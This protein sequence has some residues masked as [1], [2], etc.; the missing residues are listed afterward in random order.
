MRIAAGDEGKTMYV[1]CYGSYEYLVMPFGL[2]NAS[3]TF[4]NLLNDVFLDYIDHFMVV[5]LDDILVYSESS[6]DHL[7]TVK[8]MYA[9]V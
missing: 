2:T 3:A 5:Y 8:D 4:C 6:Q 9:G 1:T 7:V